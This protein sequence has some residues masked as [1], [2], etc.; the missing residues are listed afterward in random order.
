[1]SG[2]DK[3]FNTLLEEMFHINKIKGQLIVVTHSP[4]I[5][6]DDYHKYIRYGHYND[7]LK[8]TSGNDVALHARQKKQLEM[9]LP[10]IKN[11]LFSDG[12]ILVE[13]ETEESAMPIFAKR[14][15]ISLV[16]HNVDIVN[17]GGV[18]NIPPLQEL[19]ETLGINNY[20]IIDNDGKDRGYERTNVTKEKDFEYECLKHMDIQNV[21][22]YL[23]EFEEYINEN[24]YDGSFWDSFF[25]QSFKTNR[26]KKMRQRQNICKY[27]DDYIDKIEDNEL[28]AIKDGVLEK[29]IKKNIS[30][31]NPY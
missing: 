29:I 25:N 18:K 27:V 6:S 10:Y 19:F 31:T 11:S 17:S 23:S 9:Q 3:E 8:I 13:G 22:H 5:L 24:K 28:L 16:R 30:K 26:I 15:G 4:Y 2:D 7:R 12:V 14:L 20:A 21:N 1:M